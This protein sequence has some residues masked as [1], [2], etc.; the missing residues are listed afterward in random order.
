MIAL[1]DNCIHPDTNRPYM[2]MSVGGTDPYP[3]DHQEDGFTHAF[4][5]EFENPEDRKYFSE[6]DPAHMAFIASMEGIVEKRQVVDFCPG[7]F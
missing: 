6:S 7:V 3:Q 1:K 5:S 2:K 4:I